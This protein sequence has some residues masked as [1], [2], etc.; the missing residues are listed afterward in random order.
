MSELINSFY[1]FNEGV[2]L[3]FIRGS[4]FILFFRNHEEKIFNS[5]LDITIKLIFEFK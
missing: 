4:L 1:L 2:L 5:K 3:A